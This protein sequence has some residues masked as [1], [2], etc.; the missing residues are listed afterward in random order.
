MSRAPSL[1]HCPLG[2][3]SAVTVQPGTELPCRPLSSGP[4][5]AAPLVVSSNTTLHLGP[6]SP[7]SC[8]QD[9]AGSTGASQQGSTLLSPPASRARRL[10][11]PA[12]WAW[13]CHLP[14]PGTEVAE[15]QV[16]ARALRGPYVHLA[17]NLSRTVGPLGS[18][19]QGRI[20]CRTP[21]DSCWE[22]TQLPMPWDPRPTW[23]LPRHTLGD[24]PLLMPWVSVPTGCDRPGDS[25]KYSE[26]EA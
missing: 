10:P 2:R 22:S 5:L 14:Q 11:M 20:A 7:P 25:S 8:N 4:L 13:L 24:T 16:P 1:P 18:V 26:S 9:D 19:T 17:L 21:G 23:E 15:S 3:V 12:Q 6:L